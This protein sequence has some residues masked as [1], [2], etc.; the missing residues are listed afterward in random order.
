MGFG[1]N[2]MFVGCRGLIDRRDIF[3][4][5]MVLFDDDGWVVGYLKL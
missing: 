1:M 2:W 5:G 3:E 4:G